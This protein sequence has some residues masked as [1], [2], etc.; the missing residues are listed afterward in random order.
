MTDL[1][2]G[3]MQGDW[4]VNPVFYYSFRRIQRVFFL[5]QLNVVWQRLRHLCSS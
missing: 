4:A 2:F 3:E 5:I 1:L